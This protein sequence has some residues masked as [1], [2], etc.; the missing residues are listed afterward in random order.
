MYRSS[1]VVWQAEALAE[2]LAE[3]DWSATSIA[4]TLSPDAPYFR[5]AS[6]GPAG[7]SYVCIAVGVVGGSFIACVCCGNAQRT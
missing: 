7:T 4:V 6:E 5:V 3:M 2:G 1:D